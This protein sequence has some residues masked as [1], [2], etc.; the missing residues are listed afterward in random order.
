[1]A[2]LRFIESCVVGVTECG[3]GPSR[4]GKPINRMSNKSIRVQFC[5]L[6]CP[7]IMDSYLF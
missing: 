1:M 5:P 4:L 7:M 6:L 3:G 2:I